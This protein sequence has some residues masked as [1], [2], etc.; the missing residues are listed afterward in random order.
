MSDPPGVPSAL[1]VERIEWFAESGDR[2]TVLLTGRWRRRRPPAGGQPLLVVEAQGVRH[3]FPAMPEPPSLS[4][5]APGTWRMSFSIP[6]SLAPYLAQRIY[7]QLGAMVVPLPPAVEAAVGVRA[8]EQRAHAERGLRLELEE[9]LAAISSRRELSRDALG[10]LAATEERVRELEEQLVATRRRA[11]EAEHFAAAARAERDRAVREAIRPKLREELWLAKQLPP[12]GARSVRV[13]PGVELAAAMLGAEQAIVE[14]QDA[15]TRRLE[16]TLAAL[17]GEL[18]GMRSFAARSA[19]AYEAVAHLREQIAAI[20]S[21]GGPA[22]DQGETLAEPASVAP[23][24]V[25]PAIDGA[26]LD[27]ARDRLRI[28]GTDRPPAAGKPWLWPVFRS[29]VERDAM[30]AG[31]LLLALLPAQATVH[32]DP[33]AYDL[34]TGGRACVRVTVENTETAVEVVDSPRELAEV[35]FQMHGELPAIARLVVAGRL[36]RLLRR[37]LAEIKGDGSGLEALRSLLRE[38]LTLL[39]LYRAGVRLDPLMTLT[40]AAAMVEPAWTKGEWFTLAHE[41]EG[42]PGALSYL[43]V[44]DRWRPSAGVTPAGPVAATVACRSEALLAVLAGARSPDVHVRGE[45]RP[46]ALVQNWLEL[47]QSA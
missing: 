4:G 23:A 5:A 9:Q 2:L 37:G 47:A 42:V 25:E 8:A 43:H 31:R 39:E 24:P 35:R 27:A 40:L 45:E 13:L 14:Q 7:L 33:I 44:R 36:R 16:T 17:R 41:A 20:R 1:G 46:L 28:A 38:P 29:L 6:A 11:D 21:G 3:R 10:A 34:I 32:P 22:K 18:D 12:V 15:G 26:R 30:T 19:R